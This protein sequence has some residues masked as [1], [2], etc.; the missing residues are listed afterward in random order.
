[1]AKTGRIPARG[2]RQ[3][4]TWTLLAF[5]AGVTIDAEWS[6]LL[7]QRLT[8]YDYGFFYYAFERILYHSGTSLYNAVAEQSFLHLWRFPLIPYDQFVYPPLF[9]VFWCFFGVLPFHVSMVVWMAMNVACYGLATFLMV[10]MLWPKIRPQPAFGIAI[11]V[12]VLAP[13]N[14]DTGV[15]NVDSILLLAVVGTFYWLIRKPNSW[16]A[17][18]PLGLAVAFKVTPVAIV[19]YLLL[20]RQWR[21]AAA[22][23]AATLLLAGMTVLVTGFAP[24]LYYVSHFV[25]FGHASMR[26]GPAPYNQSLFGVL[27]LFA[28]HHALSWSGAVQQRV[29]FAFAAVEGLVVL[30]VSARHRAV[31]PIDIA[32]ACL[33]PLLFSPLV[34][35]LH[36]VLVLPAVFVLMWAALRLRKHRKTARAASRSISTRNLRYPL[37]GL[38]FVAI[39]ALTLMSLPAMFAINQV[40]S[41]HADLFWLNTQMFCVQVLV[42]AAIVWTALQRKYD[43]AL[44]VAHP[45]SVPPQR[46]GNLL[47]QAKQRE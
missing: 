35:R 28:A 22:A 42:F 13:V 15:G 24:L 3:T 29:F 30:L 44:H 14:L 21:A 47:V 5:F 25:S 16:L 36:M 7:H 38:W 34:E 18:V 27:G 23:T 41:Q 17:G 33:T 12:S 32:L 8:G 31:G 11:L 45:A 40:V 19:V 39:V 1:M 2:V 4:I 43:F 6:T 20:R 26:N 46:D 9:A 10:R 37:W